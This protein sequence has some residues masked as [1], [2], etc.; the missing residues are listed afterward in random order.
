[1]FSEK[2][3][4]PIDTAFYIKLKNTEDVDIRF[5]YYILDTL[6]LEQTNTQAGVPGLNRNDAY[7]IKIPLPPL[8]TQKQIVARIEKM[9]KEKEK[10]K[11]EINDIEQ[12]IKD[13]IADVW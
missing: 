13:E 11:R 2:N 12:K 3:G 4:F 8:E 5:L 6:E 9:E 7:K 1:V 10:K